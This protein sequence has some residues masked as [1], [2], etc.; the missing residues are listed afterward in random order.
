VRSFEGR[1]RATRPS[2]AIAVAALLLAGCQADGRS[3]DDR[4]AAPRVVP[5][6]NP[7]PAGSAQPGLTVTPAGHLNLSWQTLRPD[8]SL[9]LH[10]ASLDPGQSGGWS[11]ARDVETGTAMLGGSA[12]VPS[13]AELPSGVLVAAWRGRQAEGGHGYDIA[14]AHSADTGRTWS[15]PSAPHRD[16]T[17]TEHGFVSWL[18]LGD[19]SGMIWVDGRG[20]ADPDTTRRATRLAYAAIDARGEVQPETFVD[21]K[22]CDCCHTSSAAVPGGA[23]VAYR[24]RAEGEIRDI[25]VVRWAGGRWSEPATVHA[26][27]WH[28]VGC[29]VNGPAI[30]A[31]GARVAVAWFTAAGDTPRVRLA[32]SGDT[33]TTFGA[34]IAID[35]GRPD[36]RVG[37]V[38]M[39]G[40]DAVVSWI[41][42]RDRTAVLRLRRIAPDGARSPA[43]DVAT[44]GEGRWAGG[45]PQL[46]LAGGEAFLA[47]TDAAT[48]RVA[49]ARVQLP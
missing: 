7:A 44:F 29:P 2:G 40:G 15:P 3:P 16:G 11:A 36:G 48:N 43:V 5:M 19:T 41:E 10:F 37:V 27:R 22:I 28:Y 17:T 23:V 12:D 45:M 21:L 33:A 6:Q 4:L 47:W 39:P 35:D 31:E 42:R 8:S 13:V 9:S 32:F 46:A 34:P 1:T 49:T 24:D 25:G 26:D 20:N 18:Q 30:A 38:L 14:V